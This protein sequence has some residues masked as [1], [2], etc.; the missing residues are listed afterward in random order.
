MSSSSPPATSNADSSH[1]SRA[2]CSVG[3]GPVAAPPRLTGTNQARSCPGPP[4]VNAIT[5]YRRL[6]AA[7][8]GWQSAPEDDQFRCDGDVSGHR[9]LHVPLTPEAAGGASFPR[10]RRAA[11]ARSAHRLCAVDALAD[12]VRVPGM[13][14]GF[15]DDMEQCAACRPARSGFEPGGLG[16]QVGVV[17][18]RK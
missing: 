3:S 1:G 16:K 9:R 12:D 5:S 11:S 14:S 17:Q 10:L 2:H 4:F 15:G 18:G 8:A 6:P 13:L 7:T